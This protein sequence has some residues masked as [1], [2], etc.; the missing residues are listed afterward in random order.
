[1]MRDVIVEG[2]WTIATI[3]SI[4]INFHLLGIVLERP[5]NPREST[6]PLSRFPV[7]AVPAKQARDNTTDALVSASSLAFS[8]KDLEGLPKFTGMLSHVVLEVG[9]GKDE[10]EKIKRLFEYWSKFPPC[11]LASNP[12]NWS[13]SEITFSMLLRGTREAK[14]VEQL[15]QLFNTLPKTVRA[16]FKTFEILQA[17]LPD[18]KNNRL[19][20][21]RDDSRKLF[22]AIMLNSI[23]LE[24]P[25]HALYIS[26][27]CV[28]IQPNWLNLVDYRTRP[29]NEPFWMQGSVFRGQRSEWTRNMASFLHLSRYS[30]Y[31]LDDA[32]FRTWYLHSVVPYTREVPIPLYDFGRWD[33]DL[34]HYLADVGR[35][36]DYQMAASKFRLTNTILNQWN[37]TI[38]IPEIISREPDVAI[39]CGIVPELIKQV[40][41]TQ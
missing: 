22:S 37:V 34:A 30:I 11:L 5:E 3:I 35:S 7:P 15:K 40:L 6:A 32:A 14:K 20:T 36:V 4:S 27:D 10:E 29:P 12:T 1:M 23:K 26:A 9:E 31:N 24:K 2:L 8:P 19:E 25:N 21:L 33:M 13:Q 41:E 39:A 38:N 17:G 18:L 28:P 16:C